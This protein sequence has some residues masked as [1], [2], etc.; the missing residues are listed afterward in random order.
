MGWQKGWTFYPV[1]DKE[2]PIHEEPKLNEPDAQN[3]KELWADFLGAI[4]ENR[5]PICDIEEIH[6]STNCALL[7]M[8]SLKHGKSIEWDGAK[9]VI[10]GDEAANKLLRRDYRKG[11]EYPQA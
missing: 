5:K 1:N 9:E 4:E 3:I 7:G 8:L 11:W 2:A 6:L 10:G